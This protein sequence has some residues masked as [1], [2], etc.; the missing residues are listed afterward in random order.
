[1]DWRACYFS[2]VE[3]NGFFPLVY[4]AIS[5]VASLSSVYFDH[6]FFEETVGLCVCMRVCVPPLL[7]LA[8]SA[9]CYSCFRGSLNP[10]AQRVQYRQ[11]STVVRKR[12][13]RQ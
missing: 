7:S 1:M 6:Y 10:R 4:S 13:R 9:D 11:L 3:T 8:P 12:M 2:N 5:V